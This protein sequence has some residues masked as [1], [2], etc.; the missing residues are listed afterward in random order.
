MMNNQ[1]KLIKEIRDFVENNNPQDGDIH[2]IGDIEWVFICTQKEY[3]KFTDRKHPMYESRGYVFTRKIKIVRGDI[4][5]GVIQKTIFLDD[6]EFIN[7]SFVNFSHNY[8]DEENKYWVNKF[9]LEI[10]SACDASITFENCRFHGK[11]K[12]RNC[13]TGEYEHQQSNK[14]KIKCLKFINCEMQIDE[15]NQTPHLRLG[16]LDVDNF[17]LK[18]LRVPAGGEVNIGDCRFNNFHLSNFRN[19]GK[20]RIYKINTKVE[21][22]STGEFRIDNTSIGDAEFQSVKVATFETRNI[23]D[24]ILAGLRYTDW[25][26]EKYNVEVD[27]YPKDD[28]DETKFAKMRDSYRELKIV[29]LNNNDQTKA[30]TFYAK[31]MESH[32][33]LVEIKRSKGNIDWQERMVLGFNLCTNNFGQDW[34]LPIVWI[35]ALG[36]AIYGYM[37]LSLTGGYDVALWHKFPVFLNPVHKTEF[38]AKGCWTKWTYALDFIFRPIEGAFI[39]QA[40][41]AFRRYT[42]KF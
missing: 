16:F 35:L 19:L 27:E 28:H 37:L 7:V 22:G 36:S 2:I 21:A 3:R 18:N 20:F 42:R 23:Y 24:N 13:D 29:A 15:A 1:D 40:I 9:V 4:F 10:L 12:I 33:A 25:H 31:E 32:R 41:Q 39:Y 34:F 8:K 11:F 14:A 17:V 6:I 26:W 38:I 30:I 5:Y